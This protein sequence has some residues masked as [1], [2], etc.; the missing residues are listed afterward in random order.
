MTVE[1]LLRTMST[2]ELLEWRAFL[3]VERT[4]ALSQPAIDLDEKIKAVFAPLC[5]GRGK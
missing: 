4:G 5:F 1:Q 2:R 3:H